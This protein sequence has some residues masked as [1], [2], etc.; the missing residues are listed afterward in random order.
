MRSTWPVRLAVGVALV[1]AQLAVANEFAQASQAGGISEGPRSL[2]QPQRKVRG[3]LY[4]RL[5]K[6][7][8]LRTATPVRQHS[9]PRPETSQPR[10]V[11]GMTLIPIDPNVDPKIYVEPRRGD[12]RYSIRAIPPPVCR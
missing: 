11:C 3:N 12:M 2:L 10:V 9:A 4:G 7:S 5:F 8:D 1:S 6:T